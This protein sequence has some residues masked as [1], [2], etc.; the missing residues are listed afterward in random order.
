LAVLLKNISGFIMLPFIIIA[1]DI[2]AKIEEKLDMEIRF[3]EAYM[4]YRKKIPIL[5]PI[6]LWVIV[7]LLIGIP[8]IIIKV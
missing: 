7:I 3:K 4:E 2:E 8:L 6:W 5:G 1:N